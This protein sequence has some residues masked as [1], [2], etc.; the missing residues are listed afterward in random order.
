MGTVTIY[1]PLLDEG[2]DCWRPIEAE[3]LE[4]EVYRVN[5]PVPDEE[6]WAFPPGSL[7]R[8]RHRVFSDCEG[9]EAAE[10]VS[11]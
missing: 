1:M 3:A 8:C 5:G 4:G 7:V 2:I 6:E 11:G 10:R 9:M